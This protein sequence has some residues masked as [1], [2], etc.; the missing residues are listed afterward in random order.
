M[1]ASGRT[2]HRVR[3]RT[4]ASNRVLVH[5]TPLAPDFVGYPDSEKVPARDV[6]GERVLLS[7][8]EPKLD[9]WHREDEER[10]GW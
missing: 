1:I 2:T 7:R 3:N 4:D 5:S 6:T 10:S 9:Y 8:P